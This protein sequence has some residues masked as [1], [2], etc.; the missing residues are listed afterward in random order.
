MATL[1]LTR[2]ESHPDGTVGAAAIVNSNWLRLEEVFNPALGAA[3]DSYEAVWRAFMRTDSDPTTDGSS[4][5]WDVSLGT[6]KPIWREGFEVVTYAAAIAFDLLGA[7]LQ[8]V[9]L[10]GNLTFS[11]LGNQTAGRTVT[12]ILIVADG[13]LRTLTFP[14]WTFIGAAAPANIAA[15]KTGKLKVLATGTLAADVIVE[16]SVEA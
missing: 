12:S 9:S 2:L 11:A 14:A 13:S 7:K 3:D 1:P 10:T 16:W 5:E 4:M 8:K 6:P 15:N